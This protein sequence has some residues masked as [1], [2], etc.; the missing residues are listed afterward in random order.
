MNGKNSDPIG[1]MNIH[2]LN[3]PKNDGVI[4]KKK[5][6]E[7]FFTVPV[8]LHP[9]KATGEFAAVVS[10]E[11]FSDDGTSDIIKPALPI[12]TKLYA[13]PPQQPERVDLGQFREAVQYAS[14]T[15]PH[16]DLAP[17]LHELLTLI[18]QQE[19]KP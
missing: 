1:W 11:T 17:K 9:H 4:I 2:Q 3:N 19:S 6:D 5:D 18:N 12:G 14:R 10:G 16:E 8:Y 13:A 7:G 15:C